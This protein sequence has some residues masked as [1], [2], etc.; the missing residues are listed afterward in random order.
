MSDTLKI[1]L[2][3]GWQFASADGEHTLIQGDLSA[4]V[5]PVQG[6]VFIQFDITPVDFC[7]RYALEVQGNTRAISIQVNR[8]AL[9]LENG[10]HDV[11]DWVFLED[12][13]LRI[14]VLPDETLHVNLVRTPCVITS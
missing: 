4:W 13:T 14:P 9:T 3:Q 6:E 10:L 5:S 12:N 1:P 11:T 7:A 8:H 2:E